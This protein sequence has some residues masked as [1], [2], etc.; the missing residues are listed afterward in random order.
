[1]KILLIN[2]ILHTAE[3]G[4]IPRHKSNRDCMIYTMARGFV[5]NGH[6]VT[7][8]ASEEYRPE[9]EE[10]NGFE[11][12][13]FPSRWPKVFRPDL[14]PWPK[15][16]RAWLKE[17]VA[18]YDLIV[19]SETFSL[20]TL[21]AAL[22]A[23][24]KTV[25]WQELAQHQRFMKELP[26]RLWYNVIAPLAMKK[27]TVIG[28]SAKARDFMKKFLPKVADETVDHGCDALKFHPD[29]E[30]RPEDAFIIISQ[31]IE[32]KR[33]DVMLRAFLDLLRRPGY[34][35]YRLHVVGRG[36]L[37][38]EMRKMAEAAGASANVIFHGFM[39]QSE[40]A[41]LSRRTKGMLVNTQRDLNMVSIPESIVNGTPVLTNPVPYVAPFIAENRLGIVADGWGADELAEMAGNY[42]GFHENCMRVSPALTNTGASR[43]ITEIAEKFN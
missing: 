36:P 43:R 37:E 20:G 25:I 17:H 16:L 3:K 12:V 5:D 7:L 38:S 11:V 30:A 33:P 1:M 39:P 6:E 13:Y 10:E 8:L 4:V 31:L 34:G 23:P 26:S 40:F 15:G 21:F 2:L 32:R 18:D 14:L 9:E 28:R 24:E 29:P 35:H 19:T 22:A 27:A 41:P 42:G